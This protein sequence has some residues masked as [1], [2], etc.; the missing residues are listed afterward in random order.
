MTVQIQ[1]IIHSDPWNADTDMVLGLST[2]SAGGSFSTDPFQWNS[3]TAV[4]IQAGQNSADFYYRDADSGTPTLT[5]SEIPDWGWND[6]VQQQTVT[7]AG[8]RHQSHRVL[9]TVKTSSGAT[10]QNGDLDFQA[11]MDGH[12]SEILTG[13]SAACG[14][15]GGTW[16]LDSANFPSGWAAGEILHVDFAD[17]GS[18]EV[19]RCDFTLTGAAED[20]AGQTTLSLEPTEILALSVTGGTHLLFT[21]R[22][23][24]GV[25]GY[26]VYRGTTSTFTPDYSGGSNRVGYLVN[27]QN[28]SAPDVQWTDN[29]DV[30]GN[31]VIN[32]F[33]VVTC[34]NSSGESAP[35]NRVGEFDY[36]LVT[37]E[38][39]NYSMVALPLAPLDFNLDMASDLRNQIPYCDAVS[40]W[41]VE[42]QQYVTYLPNLKSSDFAISMNGCYYISVSQNSIYTALG[43]VTD[44][45]YTLEPSSTTDFNWV[46]LPLNRQ[47]LSKASDLLREIAYSNS[48]AWWNPSIQGYYQ[49]IAL[50]PQTDFDLQVGYPYF[51]NVTREVTWPEGGTM[52]PP[53]ASGEEL[54]CSRAANLPHLVWGNITAR[55]LQYEDITLTAFV[56]G[57][58]SE[59][60]HGNSAGSVLEEDCWAVQCGSFSTAWRAGDVVRI[61]FSRPDG[62]VMTRVDVVLTHDPAD[63]APDVALSGEGTRPDCYSLEQN[64]P[65]PFNSGTR[66]QYQLPEKTRVSLQIFNMMGQAV[67]TLV[68]RVQEAGFYEAAWDGRDEAGRHLGSGTYVMR[69]RTRSFNRIRK[70][71]LLQ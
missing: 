57:R 40:R 30:A 48:V 9:G 69:M 24:D 63:R 1:D 18:G 14:Y 59:R 27:D 62:A 33:Y 26:N 66:I 61:L 19:G 41:D 12:G 71:I 50:L 43:E 10:P 65:N 47:D 21:W 64:Y 49:Y 16:W 7:D 5:V 45:Q 51:V 44:P 23:M 52:K 38:T 36:Q 32:Y 28:G 58:S 54:P 4:T 29:G 39:T 35:S 8:S 22:S 37:S 70:L 15:D 31:S 34:V 42:H 13:Q 20:N 67:R 3:D 11:W 2:S 56:L 6:A 53:A 25:D 55:D 17:R 46:M 60:L 68:D